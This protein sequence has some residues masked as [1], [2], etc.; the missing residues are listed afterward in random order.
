MEVC[1]IEEGD[2]IRP[3][4][5]PPTILSETLRS[6]VLT[7]S[8][9]ASVAVFRVASEVEKV[10]GAKAIVRVERKAVRAKNV[11]MTMKFRCSKPF[12]GD[13]VWYYLE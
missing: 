6:T 12:K 3:I 7:V 2:C 13:L 1:N 4:S 9:T 11:M 5:I 8:L 10:R